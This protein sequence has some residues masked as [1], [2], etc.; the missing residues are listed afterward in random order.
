MKENPFRITRVLSLLT[1]TMF[2]LC[3]LLVLLTAA[4]L[5]RTLVDRGE[6][7]YA[8]RTALQYLT[9]RV[10]QA[11]TVETG[12]LDNCEALILTE[13]VDGECYTTHIYCYEGQLRELYSVPGAKLPPQAGE[14]ILAGD[15][16][17]PK[18]EENLLTITFDEEA[19]LLQLPAGRMVGS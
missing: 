16:F 7:S 12:M 14:A 10:R 8:R 11:E 15:T 6:A 4:D 1:L 19:L 5:Y 2:T 9:T 18:L 13:T 3:V 17:S